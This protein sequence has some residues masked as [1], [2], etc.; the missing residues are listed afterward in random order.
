ML[1]DLFVFGLASPSGSDLNKPFLGVNWLFPDATGPV[2]ATWL[3][4][5]ILA[6]EGEP[7]TYYYS[8]F[9][10]WHVEISLLE[11]RVVEVQR[12]DKRA[13]IEQAKADAAESAKALDQFGLEDY[14]PLERASEP[15]EQTKEAIQSLVK[16]LSSSR[17]KNS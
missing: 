10:P 15:D 14:S 11:G 17:K 12:H 9:W 8:Q 3:T 1:D 2:A 7:Y 6:A 13:E 16:Q 4:G 5:K